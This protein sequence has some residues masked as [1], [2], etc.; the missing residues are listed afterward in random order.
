ME[1]RVKTEYVKVYKQITKRIL[2]AKIE[3]SRESFCKSET[4]K[5]F[6]E[7]HPEYKGCK[8]SYEITEHKYF[9][10]LFREECTDF[11]EI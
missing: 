4:H 8:H 9:C 10:Y 7:K 3:C 1:K 11:I 6:M 5:L 2:L